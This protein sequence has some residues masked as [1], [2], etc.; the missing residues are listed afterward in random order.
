MGVGTES[1]SEVKDLE[2]LAVEVAKWVALAMGHNPNPFWVFPDLYNR[3]LEVIRYQMQIVPLNGATKATMQ[4]WKFSKDLDEP[5]FTRADV[6]ES[7]NLYR[8]R[9]VHHS[10][11]DMAFYI[12]FKNS[13]AKPFKDALNLDFGYSSFPR[14]DEWGVWDGDGETVGRTVTLETLGY[15][16]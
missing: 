4:A 3:L 11:I 10:V 8:E 7:L 1:E 13:N 15:L 6:E 12:A 14:V 9:G 16:S 5:A 2:E